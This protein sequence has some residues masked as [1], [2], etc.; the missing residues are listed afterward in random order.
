MSASKRRHVLCRV[1]GLE[2]KNPASSS[3]CSD[4]GIG[5]A[6]ENRKLK[7]EIRELEA[8]IRETESQRELEASMRLVRF[9][10]D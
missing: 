3:M 8:S 9:Y 4:C 7:E 1:C 5:Y 2:H 10:Q 6:M